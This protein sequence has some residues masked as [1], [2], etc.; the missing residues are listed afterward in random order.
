MVACDIEK[1][2]CMYQEC[3]DCSNKEVEFDQNIHLGKQVF[4]FTW[5]TKH[6]EKAIMMNGNAV[7]KKVTVTAKEN[8]YGTLKVLQEEVNN[9]INRVARHFFNIRHKFR[10]LI[11]LREDLT[12]QLKK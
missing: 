4:W 11:Y 5:K 3:R 7:N 9:Y 6:V 10:T 1:K 12:Y 8:D 2:E